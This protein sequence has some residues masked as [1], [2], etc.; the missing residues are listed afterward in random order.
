[1]PG[2]V[3]LVGVELLGEVPLDDEEGHGSSRRRQRRLP[4]GPAGR[5]SSCRR[6]RTDRPPAVM[7]SRDRSR[8][9]RAAPSATDSVVSSDHRG[10]ERAPRRRRRRRP[11]CSSTWSAATSC[12]P[13]LGEEAADRLSAPT[14]ARCGEV[15][16]RHGGRVV[17]PAA[18]GSWPPSTRRTDAVR[19]AVAMQQSGARR[20][21]GAAAAG[22][23][24]RRRRE[25]GGRRLLRPAGG[26]RRPAEAEAEAG[27]ILVSTPVRFLAG[28]RAGDARAVGPLELKGLPEPVEAFEVG[29]DRPTATQR[30]TVRRRPAVPLAL[31]GHRAP[32]VRRAAE[33]SA[34][35]E[36]GVVATPRRRAADRA[37]RRRGRRGQ[38]PPGL[39][40]RP[41]LPRRRGGR[42]AGGCDAE[43]ALPYQPWVQALD[44]LCRPCRP[45]SPSTARPRLADAR[46][47]ARPARAAG[48]RAAAPAAGRPRDRALPPVR[49]R[50]RRARRRRPALADAG[51]ARRPALGRRPRRWPCCATWPARA[52]RRGL[53]VV[54]TFRDTGDEVTEPLAGCLADLRRIDGTSRLRLAGL[55]ADAVERFVADAIGHDARR[56]PARAGRGAGRPQR[57]QRLLRRRAVAP[58]RGQRRR[59]PD[60]GRWVVR[61]SAATSGVPDSVPEVVA[62]RLGRLSPPARRVVELA[63]VAGQRVEL[64]V[65]ALA[66]DLPRGE[67]ER[68]VDE[69]VEAKLLTEVGGLGARLPVRP[70]HRARHRRGGHRR[71]SPGRRLHLAVGRG[72]RDRLRGRPAAGAGRAGPP[73]RRRGAA[74]RRRKA[75]YYGRRAAAQALRSV[76]YDE[77]IGHLERRRSSWPPVVRQRA[78]SSSS[79]ATAQLPPRLTTPAS[80]ASLRRRLPRPPE[81]GA[82]EVAAEAAVGVRAARH[83]PGSRA[84][85]R[86]SVLEALALLGDEDSPLRT[87][88]QARWPGPGHAG[89]ND[90]AVETAEAPWPPPAP[91]ATP[92][93]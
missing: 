62:D 7:T 32:S 67:L 25:L 42:A 24:G 55:D 75:V 83:S 73:L 19:A 11:S 57:R 31:G 9:R 86:W 48:A 2:L 69:L 58:P 90:E 29:W 5:S 89:R 18:T 78:E 80:V 77:A 40:V 76:A 43:L 35:L 63:A 6:Q 36:P 88:L 39:R 85:R 44:H 52:R 56:R 34:E 16:L 82:V 12:G 64:R 23:R 66:A 81:L 59:R 41:A 50:R 21:D 84:A 54:G 46:P 14:S 68:R 22:R 65:L 61:G 10:R 13:R 15:V 30:P 33:A 27:Q 93:A 45:R 4:A 1:M 38:D 51:R 74:R 26:D 20:R 79:S 60:G 87:R 71:R 17:T 92:R 70:R 3:E 28:D 72:H 37:H 47:A 91:S 8:Y 49:R 53:L